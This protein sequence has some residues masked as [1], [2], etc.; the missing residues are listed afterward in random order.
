MTIAID[1]ASPANI[2]AQSRITAALSLESS[3]ARM[4]ARLSRHGWAAR[5]WALSFEL[6][7]AIALCF[8]TIT[9]P[10]VSL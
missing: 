5:A 9:F 8:A 7:T 1:I 2:R 3:T 4:E 10:M 6:G